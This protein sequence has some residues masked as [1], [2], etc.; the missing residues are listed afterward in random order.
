MFRCMNSRRVVVPA[1]VATVLLMTGCS[2]AEFARTQTAED[3][4]HAVVDASEGMIEVTTLRYVGQADDYDVYFARGLDDSGTLCL[5]LVLD[6]EWQGTDCERG[7][8]SVP[9]SNGAH[10]EVGL[11]YRGGAER[12][13]LSENVWVGRK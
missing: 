7:S 11:N 6:D 4:P 8:V 5:S 3:R 9:I 2:P 1:L 13:M 10:V 12:E